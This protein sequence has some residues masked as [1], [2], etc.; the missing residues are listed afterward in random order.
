MNKIKAEGRINSAFCLKHMTRFFLSGITAVISILTLTLTISTLSGANPSDDTLLMRVYYDSVPQLDALAGYD[1]WEYNNLEAHYVLVSGNAAIFQELQA[2]GWQ[3]ELDV[4]QTAVSPAT[5]T[6][7]FDGYRTVDELYAHLNSLNNSYPTLTELVVYG[8]SHCQQQGGCTT[9]GNDFHPGF[10]LVAL[11]ISNESISGTSTISNTKIISGSKPV[12]FLMANIHAREITTPELAMRMADWLLDGYGQDADATWLVDHHEIWIVPTAN[13]DGH[14]LTELGMLY[15]NSPLFHRKNGNRNGCTVWPS[16]SYSQYGVDLNRNHSFGWGGAGSSSTAC[17]LVFRGNSAT[18]EPETAQLES[19]VTALI[20]DQRGSNIGDSAPQ[21]SRGIFITIH[22]YSELVLWPWGH[23]TAPAPNQIGLQ[24]IGDKLA[25]FNGYTSCQP[26]HCLY[27]ASGTSDDWAYGK[28]GIPAFTFEVGTQ[29]M[30]PFSEV[31]AIQWP[32]NRPAFQYA[33]KLARTPYQLVAGP[34]VAIKTAV[35]ISNQITITAVFDNSDN[36][37]L[38]IATAAYALDTPYWV[39]GSITQTISPLDGAF[40]SI[41]E[42]GIAVIDLATIS[43]GR[44]TLFLRAQDNDG[45]WGTVTAVFIYNL[46]L[47]TYL[48]IIIH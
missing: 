47:K 44:H 46:P 42:T 15:G 29:F 10:D 12:F 35:Y 4:S 2:E 37:N 36:G 39:S 8:E 17:S 33:A 32:Q 38:P 30:P 31:D 22:S 43:N 28:L 1:V 34:D 14:W 13:P 21:N 41:I 23:T 6:T 19:L 27:S 48:P 45:N 18:S 9:P 3:V 26:S 20:A 24:A 5:T 40:D 11:R 25:A 16:L 7:Y